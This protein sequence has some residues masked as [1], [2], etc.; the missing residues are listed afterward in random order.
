MPPHTPSEGA[1]DLRC[2]SCGSPY[3]PGDNF[4]RRCGSS[5]NQASSLEGVTLPAVRHARYEA[6]PWRPTLPV[7]VRGAAVI[8]AG[9]LAEMFLRG[10][11]S[12]LLRGGARLF[13]RGH[14]NDRK[15][16]EVVPAQPVEEGEEPEAQ[17]VSESWFFRR[18]RVRR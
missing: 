10:L 5:L 4:C 13:G 9:A 16:T 17:I 1:S 18:V 15:P 3:D 6:V 2:P 14:K 7:V 12:R 8:A 11:T